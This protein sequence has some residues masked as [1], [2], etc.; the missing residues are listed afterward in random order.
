ME[1]EFFLSCWANEVDLATAVSCAR[2]WGYDGAEGP[3]PADAGE[4]QEIAAE[5]KT[6]GLPYIAEIATGGDYVP[7]ARLSVTKHLDDLERHLSER[8]ADF[9]PLIVNVLGGSDRWSFAESVDFFSKGIELA[10]QAGVEIC[11]ETHR[12]RPTFNPWVTRDLLLELPNI[13]L[14]CDFSHWCAVCERLVMDEEP[15]ILELCA[16][17]C[18]HLHARVGYA[19]GP[20]VPDPRAPFYSHELE[21]HTQWW[22]HLIRAADLRGSTKFSV[23]PEFGPD[24]YL[25][26]RPF[27]SEPAAD[28]RELNRWVAGILRNHTNAGVE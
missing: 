28:L 20:Q 26:C 11:W 25:Q 21:S 22:K 2:E 14:N 7:A 24:G 5:I 4:R 19:Q 8:V 17:R 13:F 18:R 3:P 10:A 12:S 23:T 9:A 27:T 1:I 6:Q 15:E 16:A